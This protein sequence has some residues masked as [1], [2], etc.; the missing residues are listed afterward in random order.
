MRVCWSRGMPKLSDIQSHFRD[1]V[2]QAD[3]ASLTSLAPLL[4]G[5]D[6]PEK[7]LAIHQRNYRQSLV[8]ALLVKFPATGWLMGTSFVMQAAERF[9]PEHRPTAPCIAE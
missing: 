1:A 3:S 6:E 9:V 4:A 2:I 5:G 7:R 8:E